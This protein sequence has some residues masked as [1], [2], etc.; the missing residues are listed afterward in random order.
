MK[1]R[2]AFSK[3]EKAFREFVKSRFSSTF[4]RYMKM[5]R[6][7]KTGLLSA[8]LALSFGMTA[9]AAEGQQ[10][11]T[12]AVQAQGTSWDAVKNS[13]DPWAIMR[14]LN[15]KYAAA[16]DIDAD[17]V[18]S[19]QL[20][21]AVL[22]G[23]LDTYS[24]GNIKMKNANSSDMQYVMNMD[25]DM[26][27][28]L[29]TDTFGQKERTT[30]FYTD[31]WYYYETGGQ[32]LKM[33][34]DYAEAYENAYS[35][36]PSADLVSADDM[37]Y[38]TEISMVRN[39]GDITIYYTCDGNALMEEVNNILGAAGTGSTGG[40]KDAPDVI[41]SGNT[42]SG[43]QAV[44]DQADI[45]MTIDTCKAQFTVDADGNYKDQQILM[46]IRMGEGET[47][48]TLNVFMQLDINA[49]GDAVQFTL[50]STDGYV[51]FATYLQNALNEVYAGM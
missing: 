36:I 15:E 6:M 34:L 27:G 46:D 49:L 22:D 38:I 39:G 18:M 12:A 33:P 51:D 23:T 1:L 40:T 9:L 2:G 3:S 19:M 47:E 30:A 26:F 14:A 43:P 25:T 32:K 35:G 31:G 4:R 29:D 41:Y 17:F 20:G 37:D 7:F 28:Q 21:M 42:G 10:N 48:F 24:T 8:A 45:P 44:P 13:D 16:T 50:P 11:E 5:K